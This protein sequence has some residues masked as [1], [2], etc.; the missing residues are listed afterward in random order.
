[1]GGKSNALDGSLM[2]E[3]VDRA[4]RK[5]HM[6]S[7]ACTKSDRTTRPCRHGIHPLAAEICNF[8]DT[9]IRSYRADATVLAACKHGFFIQRNCCAKKTVMRYDRLVAVV[10]PVHLA[11]CKSEERHAIQPAGSNAVSVEI[12]RS[13]SW[14]GSVFL[15]LQRSER[16]HRGHE[17]RAQARQVKIPGA[18][19]SPVSQHLS[20]SGGLAG[21]KCAL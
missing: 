4:V 17:I 12:E 1:L 14:H 9:S 20:A 13:D 3:I 2:L 6:R 5:A 8:G 15:R 16:T 11:I 10:E 7:P 21:L 19:K 18:L